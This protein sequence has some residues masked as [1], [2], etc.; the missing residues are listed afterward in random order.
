MICLASTPGAWQHLGVNRILNK[1]YARHR[2]SPEAFLYRFSPER[3]G[4]TQRRRWRWKGL[5]EIFPS[6]SISGKISSKDLMDASL[7]V[8]TLPVVENISFTIRTRECVASSVP[9][10]ACLLVHKLLPY[11]VQKTAVPDARP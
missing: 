3:G 6:E 8:F 10:T 1:L 11:I 2:P 4:R 5:V 9:Y 7:G